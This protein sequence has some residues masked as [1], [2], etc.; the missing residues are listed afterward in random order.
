MNRKVQIAILSFLALG[1]QFGCMTEDPDSLDPSEI[2]IKYYG[3]EATEETID[4]LEIGNG[5][6]LLGSRTD[7]T[8][9]DYYL[10]RTDSAGNRLW[11]D[12]IDNPYSAETVDIP[13]KM[14]YDEANDD[15]YI[16]GTSSFDRADDAAD[17]VL[18]DHMFLASVKVTNTEMTITDTTIHRFDDAGVLRP[19]TGA[20]IMVHNDQLIILGSV[21]SG[22]G[23][24]LDD[25]HSI[26]LL[27]MTKDF[28]GGDY[29]EKI[30]F[31]ADDVGRR[32]V[33]ANGRYFFGATVTTT[34]GIGN[35][36]VDVLVAEFDP[37]NGNIEHFMDYGTANNEDISNMIYTNPGIAIVG[38]TGSGTNQ[39]AYLLRISSNLAYTDLKT[40]TYP[41]SID[42]PDQTW[43]TQGADLAQSSDGDFFVVGKVNGF[44]DLTNDQREDEIVILPT[45]GIGEVHEG[46]VQEYG[47]V[48]EDG[49][50]AIIRRA[51]GS[52][53]IGATVHFG[54]NATMMC[55]MKTNRNG[56]FLKN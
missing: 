49:G 1:C 34:G 54:G 44:S 43:N 51:D 47:S 27:K 25:D 19:T 8:N 3:S 52:M 33:E 14:Y 5:F 16:I 48:E 42:N 12:Y 2:F 11:E 56:E 4:L 55:L 28:Q 9:S 32:L 35:G 7:G 39:Y 36:G 40:L 38:T 45:N 41:R 18:I 46:D 6:L 37:S 10:V 24:A 21:A 53:V 29:A 26:L 22:S 30:G 50:N 15:L 13:S 20:D 31:G 23:S 17:R